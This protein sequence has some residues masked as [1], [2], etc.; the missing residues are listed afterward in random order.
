MADQFT[1]IIKQGWGGRMKN[2]F[3]GIVAGILLTI[4][5]FPV[6]FL[7]EGRAKKRHQSLQEGAGIVISVPS[8]QIDPANEGRLVHVSGNAE[9][10]GTLSDPQFGVSLSSALKLRR[11]VEMYQWVQEERSETKNKVGGGTEKATTYSYVKK[12]S[13]KLQKSGDFKDPVGHQNPESMPYPEA[14]QVADPILLGAFML[15]PFFVAQLNDYS[16][17]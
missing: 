2:A 3:G 7:N 12:W 1:E 5:S 16:P 17:L 8:D 6:L 15:P 14:E 13:S 11:K 10:G 4:I 9:A